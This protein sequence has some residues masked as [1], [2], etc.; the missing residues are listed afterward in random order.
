MRKLLVV[1]AV[2][3]V[4][5]TVSAAGRSSV[6]AHVR[7]PAPPDAMKLTRLAG[8]VPEPAEELQYHVHSH[9]DVFVNGTPVVV[10]AGIGIN[11]HDPRVHYFPPSQGGPA[12][13]GITVPCQHPCISPLH[14]HD[15]TG[16]LHTETRTVRPNHL[17]Q[18]FVEWKVRL[19]RSC[20]A[21]YCAPRTRIAVYVNGKRYGGDPRSILLSNHREIAVVV[22]RPPR[23]IPAAYNGLW[24]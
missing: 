1:V 9:L 15:A 7:W 3:C 17:G 5:T 19:T 21:R 8:L 16:I 13:G 6:R 12:Y 14:T 23:H 20:V 22:G 4:A 11:I 2:L 10:P 24:P 18:F